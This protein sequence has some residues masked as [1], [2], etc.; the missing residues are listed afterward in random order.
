[1]A[2]ARGQAEAGFA[3]FLPP[4][5]LPPSPAFK[6]CS[7]YCSVPCRRR[8]LGSD[9]DSPSLDL[10]PQRPDLLVLDGC[11][12][13]R[14]FVSDA[15]SPVRLLRPVPR[16]PHPRQCWRRGGLADVPR[17]AWP[18]IP[19]GDPP[20]PT[21]LPWLGLARGCHPVPGGRCY[22]GLILLNGA[23]GGEGSPTCNAAQAAPIALLRLVCG[24]ARH[25]QQGQLSFA[26]LARCRA[27]L[28]LVTVP[29]SVDLVAG[30]RCGR[31]LFALT[32]HLY[33]F[34]RVLSLADALP[35]LFASQADALSPPSPWRKHCRRHLSWAYAWAPTA[36]LMDRCFAVVLCLMSRLL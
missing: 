5:P 4:S 28:L 8:P 15:A 29:R 18:S 23:S 35:L 21:Q 26:R 25:R 24:S 10:Q 11:C 7:S 36:R 17:G 32:H 20:S 6:P 27:G 12:G 31:H 33:I 19:G 3:R 14:P 30:G 2:A 22:G 13:D 16:Q 34:I 9:P 1:M